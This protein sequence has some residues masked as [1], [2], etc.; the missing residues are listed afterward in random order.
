MKVSYKYVAAGNP[1]E[2]KDDR[3]QKKDEVEI[4]K[5]QE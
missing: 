4:S 5:K 1:Y 2:F 3:L